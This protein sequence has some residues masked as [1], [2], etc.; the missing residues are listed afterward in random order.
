MDALYAEGTN[1]ISLTNAILKALGKRISETAPY[2]YNS[3]GDKVRVPVK[4]AYDEVNYTEYTTPE[5]VIFN[6]DI[7]KMRELTLNTVVYKDYDY[8]NLTAKAY[9][10]P[11]PV[12]IDLKIHV[13]TRNPDNDVGLNEYLMV[14]EDT[15]SYLDAEISP[16]LGQYDRYEVVWGK[17]ASFDSTDISKIREL[18]GTVHA[19][20]EVLEYDEVRLLEP[21][22][23]IGVEVEDFESTS[24]PLFVSTAQELYPSDSDIPTIG[25]LTGFPISGSLQIEDDVVVYTSRTARKFLGISGVT[26]F[27]NYD[28]KIE[29]IS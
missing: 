22:N 5:I 13:A 10:E 2:Y 24:C 26:R 6:P 14:M 27:H 20:L 9:H 25:T 21:G 17:M 16:E 19:W 28:T 29:I 15:I 8:T 4:F 3:N 11:I 18:K 23:A 1:R 12:R 7:R